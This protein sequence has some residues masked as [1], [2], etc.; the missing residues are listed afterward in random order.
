MCSNYVA[1]TRAE[2]LL[3]FFGVERDHDGPSVVT[4]PTGIAPFIRLADAGSGNK[5]V[6]DGHF[7]LLPHFA[8]ELAYGRRT[9]NARSET[10]A[11]LPSFRESW[12]KGRRCIVPTEHFFEP[13]WETGKAVR[14]LIQQHGEVPMGIAGIYSK[15]H[16]PDEKEV[17][18]FAMLTVNADQHSL[19]AYDGCHGSQRS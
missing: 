8:T 7:G 10:V 15:W 16:D 19:L 12:A 3:T 18:T 14:W 13:C 17:F 5:V 6:S 4:F 9:Y 2:R 1:V 11:N